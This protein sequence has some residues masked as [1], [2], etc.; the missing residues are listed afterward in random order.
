MKYCYDKKTEQHSKFKIFKS[1]NFQEKRKRIK[2]TLTKKKK[3]LKLKV[4]KHQVTFKKNSKSTSSFKLG[5]KSAMKS[6]RSCSLRFSP[7]TFNLDILDAKSPTVSFP[8][9]LLIL[10]NCKTKKKKKSVN[11]YGQNRFITKKKKIKKSNDSFTYV[12]FQATKL[13]LSELVLQPWI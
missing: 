2:Q 8:L 7:T 10:V 11:S 13:N 12:S 6:A 1:Q 5:Y 3:D 9:S 4:K